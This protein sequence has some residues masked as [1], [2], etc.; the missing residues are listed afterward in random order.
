MLNRV[1]SLISSI[2]DLLGSACR[3]RV[4]CYLQKL[5]SSPEEAE[6]DLM[7]ATSSG[8]DGDPARVNTTT[9]GIQHGEAPSISVCRSKTSCMEWFQQLSA[10]DQI[11]FITSLYQYYA[12]VCYPGLPVPSTFLE[13]SLKA[14]AQLQK[15]GRSNIMFGLANGLGVLRGDC[16]DSLIPTSRMPMGLLEHLVNFYQSSKVKIF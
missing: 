16:S 2:F 4:V 13:L 15:S 14:M 9:Q 6:K 11:E 10:K 7:I 8:Q 5:Y 12:S 3:S 1:H